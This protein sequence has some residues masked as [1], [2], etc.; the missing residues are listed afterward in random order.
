[1]RPA[2]ALM[3]AALPFTAT[4]GAA[5]SD[6]SL[7]RF[8]AEP[9]AAITS[10]SDGEDVLEG[11]EITVRGSVSDADD[12][13]GS[14]SVTWYLGDEV[15]CD[16]TAPADD[17]TTTCTLAPTADQG[18]IT[19]EVRDPDNAAGSDSVTLT[20]VPT[21]A[22]VATILDPTA[23]GHYYSDEKLSFQGLVSDAEDDPT[24]LTVQWQS[25]IDGTLS[26]D[27]APDS[28]GLWTTSG[29]L[30]AGQH[31]LTLTV[32]DQSGKTGADQVIV[33]V[34]QPNSA[35]SCAV[36]SPEDGGRGQEG[37]ELLLQGTAGDVDQDADTLT[38]TWESSI[39]GELATGSP[40]SDGGIQVAVSTL[41]LGAHVLTLSV[42][43]ELGE[44]C[45]DSVAWTIG[46]PPSVQIDQPVSGS[47]VNEGETVVFVGTVSDDVDSPDSL[48][49]SWASDL[50]GEWSTA[51]ADSSGTAAATTDSL[52]PGVHIVTLSA[53]DSDG[54]VATDSITLTIN[55]APTAP[56]VSIS[57]ADPTTTD[58]LGVVI[59]TDATDPEGDALSYRTTWF[60]DGVEATDWTETTVDS[61]ATA[62]GQTWTVEVV[63]QDGLTE[64]PPGTADVTIGNTA[65]TLD[66]LSL[67]P[68]TVYTDDTLTASASAS[69]VDGD[70][71]SVSYAWYVNGS[72]AGSGSSLSGTSAFDKGDEVEVVATP[73]D[74]TDE[75]DPLTS[76]TLTVQNSPPT[77]TRVSLSPTTV[78]TDDTITATVESSDDDGDTVSLTYDWTV[79]GSP[80][81]ETG[82]SL[83]G[84]TWFSSGDEIQVTVT[85]DDGEDEGSPV[86]SGTVT[87]GGSA[88]V[89]T[90]IS[91]SPSAVYT[92]TTVSASVSTSDAD[93]DPVSLSYQWYVDGSAVSATGS[94][95]DGTTWFDKGQ[96]V[97]VRVTPSDAS[98][99]GTA[100]DSDTITVLNSTPAV[101]GITLSPTS[102]YT[103]DTVTASVTATDDD[104]DSLSLSYDWFV[105]G[106]STGATG[107]SLSG[108]T[109]F[110]KHDTV[111]V[112]VTPSDGE[113]TGSAVDSGSLTVLNS[114]PSAPAVAIDPTAPYEA[115]SL[116]CEVLTDATDADG[117]AID[118]GF[119]WDVDGAA[120]TSTTTTTWPDD[121]VPPDVTLTDE[122]WTCTAMADD[123]EDLGG[124]DSDTVTIAS[125]TVDYT[126]LYN[127]DT[128]IDWSCAYGL[129]SLSFDSWYIVDSYPDVTVTSTS[130]AQPGTMVGT[131][132]TSTTVAALREIT[133]TCTETYQV[134]GTFTDANTFEGT[135]DVIFTGTTSRSCLDCTAV[136]FD[137]V[138]RR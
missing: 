46:N 126:G 82:S 34:G 132:P 74:G 56:V 134:S 61:D 113:A 103:D 86:T 81:S 27:G 6:Q 119:S 65:P 47:T 15:A 111:S 88:P 109:W 33:D 106:T 22:P 60:R 42:T 84:T 138:S 7:G 8:N 80:V 122:T 43:D 16:A 100:V 52:S 38:Y 2:L 76:S 101:T 90:S 9:Q 28:S 131:F 23:D 19:L 118:Y 55:Q 18:K 11:Y 123:G 69:D 51:S 26:L 91:L 68:A 89:V 32:T 59:D 114:P 125:A 107:S 13:E 116:W 36:T 110:D 92:N 120:F 112:Q 14:L 75:G 63:A 57:P 121:T 87:V 96:D 3:L 50:D 35:P 73:S 12:S 128:G 136:S 93:G 85:P 30:S 25:D 94:S 64:G 137:F 40:T 104:G 53:T 48:A 24:E 77:V 37:D 29:Y 49:L 97:R 21:E 79:N 98:G 20:V 54:A 78:T 117:D 45:T 62:R 4:L 102:V 127:L 10:H 66:S 99:S 41:S 124:S 108:A 31:A 70:S 115:D 130:S 67:S 72:L 83:D 71:V 39:D 58:D 95:L 1:M 129:V 17:G 135:L 105:N 5:C 44:T 133:G